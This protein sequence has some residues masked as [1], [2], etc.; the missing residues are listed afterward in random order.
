VSVPRKKSSTIDLRR[1]RKTP[2]TTVS[3]KTVK[4]PKRR[5]DVG[6]S[7]PKKITS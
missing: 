4:A 1:S 7:R 5:K 6:L 3:M 2:S